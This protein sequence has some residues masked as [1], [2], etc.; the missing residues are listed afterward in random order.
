MNNDY[1]ILI[2][3]LHAFIR[4]Y[5]KNQM[6]RGTLLS[7][8]LI[9]SLFLLV[10]IIEYFAWNTT[11][12]RTVVFYTFIALTVFVLIF[13]LIVPALKLL[14]ISKSLSESE[15]AEIIGSHFPEVKDKLL[16]TLQLQGFAREKVS[17]GEMELLLA[18]IGQKASELK[19]VPFK[20]AIDFKRNIQYLKYAAPPVL[21]VLIMLIV[22][23]AFITGPSKRIVQHSTH[24]QKPLPYQLLIT[25]QSFEV[26]QRDDFSL[27]VQVNG[28]EIPRM[29]FITSGS[30]KYLMQEVGVGEFEYTFVDLKE[31]VYFQLETN[32]LSSENYRIK[33]I[34]KPVIFNFNVDLK[35]PR[36]LNKKNET[37]ESSGDLIVPEGTTLDWKIFT[38]DT[39]NIIFKLGEE[40]HS[41]SPI[42]DN[43]FELSHQAKNNF[44]YTLI[45]G[46]EYVSGIDS[47][48]FSVQV[49]KDEYP[50]I[51]AE[52]F[53]EKAIHGFVHFSGEINDDH[54]FHSLRFFYRKDSIVQLPY[55]YQDINLDPRVSHQYFNYSIQTNKFDLQAGEGISYYFE[56]RDNDA[57]N[58]YKRSKSPSFYL[59]MPE[60]S[61][62]EEDIDKSSEEMKEK[63]KEALKELDDVE[64]ELEQ[65]R[66]SMFEKKDLSWLDK[67]KIAELLKKEESIREQVNQLDK[68]NKEISQLEEQIKEKADPEMLA[69]M[70]ELEEMFAEM[71]D[72]E[73]EKELEELQKELDKMNKEELADF[74]EEMK[75]RNE[76]LK[77]SLEQN[78]E[79][80]KE[81]EFEKLMNEAIDKLKELAEKQDTLAEQTAHKELKKDDLQKEQEDINKKFD[82]L[83]EDLKK[84]EELNKELESPFNVKRDSAGVDDI[85]SDLNEASDK[86]QKGKQKKASESQKSAAGKM[87]KMA[88]DLSAM[89]ASAQMDRLAE[90]AQQVRNMLDN[91]LDLSFKQEVLFSEIGN[92]SQNDPQYVD[93]AAELKEVKDDFDIIHDSL[94]ALSKRQAAIKSFIIKES[95]KV[96]VYLVSAIGHMQERQKGTALGQ[97]QYAMTSMNN[98]A[99]MLAESL[100][101]MK[102][103]MQ[104]QSEKQGKGKCNN[105]GGQGAPSM[106]EMLQMQQQM[107]SGMSGKAQKNGLNGKEGLNAKSKELARMAAMQGEIRRRMQQYI[108]ELER[109]GNDGSGLSKLAEEMEK[110]E[111]DIINRKISLQTLERQKQLEVRLLK[112]EKAE[113]E[114]EKKKTRESEEGFNRK[115]G[116]LNTNIEYTDEKANQQEILILSPIEMSPYYRALLNKYLYKLERQNGEQ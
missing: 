82:E 42:K 65:A 14:H 68:L 85:E 22:S 9:V 30:N 27:K 41:L 17:S 113:Q 43:H 91:L 66:L 7:V 96:N 28:E 37:I 67:Q 100:D 71:M 52:E 21:I 23:P 84:A 12:T 75:K 87:D 93:Q 114:R 101:Q 104:S 55:Q 20:R 13:N 102:E 51:K 50:L 98:L 80:F 83:A 33:V 24:F 107:N 62:V 116:N 69:K 40:S 77:N 10:D 74:L 5:Y 109:N 105:P 26:L 49:V 81:M 73:M 34:P 1:Q 36:Y 63:L 110:T 92:T 25:N 115:R 2:N 103:S 64:K 78:L 18:G 72:E 97:Q 39:R 8:A 16:N 99:L 19:P 89:M 86:L 15:A 32:D 112:S 45:P 31:D 4:K 108:E 38:R 61:E 88:S 48:Q 94:M 106:S 11:I 59:R 76:D 95:N 44:F 6:I 57:V 53:K 56:V 58:G 60:V 111:E 90:D 29:I 47:L 3:K 70:K 46:N 79:L 54:G 35:Y